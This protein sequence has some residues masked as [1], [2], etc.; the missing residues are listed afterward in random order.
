M[1]ASE[2]DL[3]H[4]VAL[5]ESAKAH[6]DATGPEAQGIGRML[7]EA[8]QATRTLQ[9]RGGVADEGIRPE[10]LTTGNDK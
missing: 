6:A 9:A 4:L 1:P 3:V 8:L 7:D 2:H 10:D 5:I